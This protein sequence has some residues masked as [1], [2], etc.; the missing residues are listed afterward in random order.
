[1]RTGQ[2]FAIS[3]G[4]RA[5]THFSAVPSGSSTAV[6]D[7]RTAPVAAF[8]AAPASAFLTDFAFVFAIAAK[9]PRP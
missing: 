5:I 1:L 6:N 7:F 3:N 4:T 8:R 2:T 9:F